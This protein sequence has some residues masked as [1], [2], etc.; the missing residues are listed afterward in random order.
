[1]RKEGDQETA[2]SLEFPWPE[3]SVGTGIIT[4][5]QIWVRKCA[6]EYHSQFK[7]GKRRHTP[8]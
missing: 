7:D 3:V 2:E 4:G 6:G 8:S 5:P 1:M